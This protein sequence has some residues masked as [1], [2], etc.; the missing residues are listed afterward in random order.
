MPASPLKDELRR[1]VGPIAQY[2]EHPDSG[3][4][5]SMP[6]VYMGLCRYVEEM[7]ASVLA[8]EAQEGH[9]SVF[10]DCIGVY[11]GQL[12]SLGDPG[13]LSVAG[14][15]GWLRQ[16]SRCLDTLKEE[17]AG[18]LAAKV[19]E[20]APDDDQFTAARLRQLWATCLVGLARVSS[21]LAIAKG[22]DLD[23]LDWQ[24]RQRTWVVTTYTL[25]GIAKPEVENE[26]LRIDIPAIVGLRD[27]RHHGSVYYFWMR[28]LSSY[29]F[30]NKGAGF[31]P[32]VPTCCGLYV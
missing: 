8:I 28:Q 18:V 23:G 10:S 5:G 12:K 26:T 6:R 19:A 31:P 29:T 27:A 24:P 17:S 7:T 20:I 30:N 16:A 9:D 2:L 32:M 21:R 1:L 15:I 4:A 14:Q 11:I 22:S 25:F 13:L 3:D